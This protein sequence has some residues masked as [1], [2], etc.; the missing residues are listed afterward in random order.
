MDFSKG[1]TGNSN[2]SALLMMVL[3]RYVLM[4]SRGKAW[5]EAENALFGLSAAGK[6]LI[7]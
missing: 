4:K 3:R 5:S 6:G 2:R 7:H 1:L